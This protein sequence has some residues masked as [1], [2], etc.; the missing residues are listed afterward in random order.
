MMMC[1]HCSAA[2][3]AQLAEAEDLKS[4]QSGFESQWGHPTYKA[5]T[6]A[7]RINGPGSG[8][9]G[10]FSPGEG[11]GIDL[12]VQQHLEGACVLDVEFVVLVD[13][14]LGEQCLVAQASVGV[15]AAGVDVGAADQ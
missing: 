9:V 4:F 11:V 8:L 2:P 7:H 13:V 10:V 14:D 5:R 15:V 6:L 1:V 12:G 3:I